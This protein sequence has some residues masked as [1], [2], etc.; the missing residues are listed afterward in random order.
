VTISKLASR[1][2]NPLVLRYRSTSGEYS[3]KVPQAGFVRSLSFGET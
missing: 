2:T 3:E 1:D